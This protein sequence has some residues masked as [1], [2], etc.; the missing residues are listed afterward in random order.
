MGRIE[1]LKGVPQHV[2]FVCMYGYNTSLAEDLE[3]LRFLRSLPRAYVFMQRYQPIPGGPM[4]DL[5]RLFDERSDDHLDA[6]IRVVFAQNMKNVER[7]YRWLCLEYARQSG[8]IH[9]GLVDTLFR[10]NYRH[11]R[12]AFL[13]QLEEM[14]CARE[15]RRSPSAGSAA[16]TAA[17]GRSRFPAPYLMDSAG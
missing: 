4:P 13:Q 5:S 16:P 12:G 3:R 9:R 6:L 10:Y 7:Y 2:E 15:P 11:M 1:L 17:L 8:R 14:A